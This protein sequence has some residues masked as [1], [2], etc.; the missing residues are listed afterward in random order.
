MALIKCPDCGKEFSDQAPA[1]P[2][3]GRP[4]NNMNI[5]MPHST[6]SINKETKNKEKSYKTARLVIGI[7]SIVLFFLVSLQ[8]CAAG[9]GNALSSSGE[10][11]GSAGFL[12]AI[13]MLISGIITICLKSKK[14][15]VAFIL[16]AVFYLLGAIIAAANIGSYS[17]LQVWAVLSSI[18]GALHIYYLSSIKQI[19]IIIR[20]VISVCIIVL[21]TLFT[22]VGKKTSVED[23]SAKVISSDSESS[24]VIESSLEQES[25]NISG[26][27][28]MAASIVNEVSDYAN[29]LTV[30]N[31]YSY[32]NTYATYYFIIVRNDSDEILG[33]GDNAIAKD[34]NGAS[35]GATSTSEDAVSPGAEI[36]L[37]NHF[38]D[39]KAESFEYTLEA[40]KEKYYDAIY[41][42]I[43]LETNDAGNKVVITC[44]NQ[45]SDP[46]LFVEA[47][48]L[49]LKEDKVV[50][51]GS[52]YVTD[53]DSEIKPGKKI[54]ADIDS[55]EDYDDVKVFITGRKEK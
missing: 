47:Y 19:N 5:S 37:V 20:I 51:Y 29:L 3:C 10:L 45:G 49:F 53:D 54:A 1:C 2:N 25:K 4:N 18:F 39:T 42:D 15:N 34:A 40:S 31:E 52:T 55:Y 17:D 12:L 13:C 46:L 14:T 27:S 11:S 36:C 41:D 28:E 30:V 22:S 48:A 38:S 7:I 43:K 23:N 24:A 16:P 8:S 44:T 9:I 50:Y 26:L 32:E 35:V 33:I 6:P 21:I